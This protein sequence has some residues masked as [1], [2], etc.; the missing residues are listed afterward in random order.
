MADIKVRVGQQ[1]AV[2]IISSVSGS[3]GGSAVVSQN[4]IGG[5]ASVTSLQVSGV[6]TFVGLSTF[7]GDAYFR[8]VYVQSSSI[9]NLNLTGI[10]TFSGDLYY[11]SFYTNGLAYFDSSGLLRST[12]SPIDAIDNT[13]YIMTTD[14]FGVPIW[15]SVIEGGSY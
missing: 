15:S 10:A 12:D 1:N 9:T 3:A 11:S 6:S 8:N 14:D 5:I 4:V 13:N 2:K 7:Q